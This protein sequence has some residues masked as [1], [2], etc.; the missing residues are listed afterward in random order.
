MCVCR[1][2]W[3][4][5]VYRGVWSAF[6]CLGPA[7]EVLGVGCGGRVCPGGGCVG[8][9]GVG[10]WLGVFEGRGWVCVL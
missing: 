8:V 10:E 5:C 3:V 1:G 9:S 7:S 6:V 2:V 4:A